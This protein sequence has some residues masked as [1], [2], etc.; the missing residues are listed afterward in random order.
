MSASSFSTPK[1]IWLDC[2]PGTCAVSLSPSVEFRPFDTA[3]CRLPPGHDDAV[4]LLLALEL[5]NINL[6]GVSCVR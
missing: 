4:A 3:L 2:D 5:D 1:N 6:L